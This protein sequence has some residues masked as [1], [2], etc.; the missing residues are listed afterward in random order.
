M[1]DLVATRT[2][3]LVA[4]WQKLAASPKERMNILHCAH[5]FLSVSSGGACILQG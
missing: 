5:A 1:L 3:D 4:H 2:F